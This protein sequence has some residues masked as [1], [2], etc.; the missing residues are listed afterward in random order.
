MIK[1]STFTFYNSLFN[2]SALNS[3][4]IITLCF[5][6]I[7]P[8]YSSTSSM[9]TLEWSNSNDRW[10]GYSCSIDQNRIIASSV[11][12]VKLYQKVGNDWVVKFQTPTFGSN[13]MVKDSFIYFSNTIN[14]SGEI[15]IYK[16]NP[17]TSWT[18]YQT[19]SPPIQDE[20][21]DD[22][23]IDGSLHYGES[24][25]L[26][27]KYLV[28]G[29]D[30]R[31]L[32]YIYEH[33]NDEWIL[34]Q[35][36]KS[37]SIEHFGYSVAI[38]D[39]TIFVGA[40]QKL[41]YTN[42]Q[43][44][45]ES[46]SIYIL[47][48]DNSGWNFTD[49]IK[50]PDKGMLG[51]FGSYITVNENHLFVSAFLGSNNNGRNGTVH[52][53]DKI[54][55]NWIY[56]Q[57]LSA[58][59]TNYKNIGF[60]HRTK[61]NGDQLA[62][63]APNLLTNKGNGAIYL[64]KK[65]N[66]IWIKN[67][68]FDFSQFENNGLSYDHCGRCIA[69]SDS[70]IVVG[71]PRLNSSPIGRIYVFNQPTV[72][73]C[74]DSID[75][76]LDG[77]IDC[78]DS[79]CINTNCNLIILSEICD[80]LIDN[81]NDGL[82]DCSDSDCQNLKLF[83]D[84]DMDGFGSMD[85]I[86][87]SSCGL[88]SGFVS[89]STDCNDLDP[90][91]YHCYEFIINTHFNT[92][93]TN[94][95]DGN[96]MDINGN[97]SLTAAFQ[98]INSSDSDELY[99][100]LFNLSYQDTI[101]IDS[102]YGI[103]SDNKVVINGKQIHSDNLI[104]F[105]G[106]NYFGFNLTNSSVENLILNTKVIINGENSKYHNCY[107]LNTVETNRYNNTDCNIVIDSCGFGYHPNKSTT[108]PN[109]N[110]IIGT[111]NLI[112]DGIQ[113]DYFV[114]LPP[115]TG[116]TLKNSTFIK[117]GIKLYTGSNYIY[118]NTFSNSS[119][120]VEVFNVENNLI[121]KNTFHSNGI[122]IDIIS[123][124]GEYFY[125]KSS[126]KIDSIENYIYGSSIPFDTIQVYLNRSNI[127]SCQGEILIGSTISNQ[128][129]LWSLQTP[130]HIMPQNRIAAIGIDQIN[131][132]SEFS[133]YNVLPTICAFSQGLPVNINPCSTTGAVL[134]LSQMTTS[135]TA[136]TSAYA[137][138]FA[139]R[140]AWLQLVI[141]STKNFLIRSNINNQIS[142]VIEAYKGTCDSLIFQGA[143]AFDS[144]VQEM[145]FENLTP[146]DTL[147]L[148]IWDKQNLKVNANEP[149]LHLTAHELSVNKDEWETCDDENALAL[150]NPT[151]ISEKDANSFIVPFPIGATSLDIA[152]EEDSL[153]A[154]GLV[155][156]DECLCNGTPLQ[157]WKA[158]NPVDMETKAKSAIGRGNVD[159]VN[160]NYIFEAQE[161]Q[162]NAY[163]TGN[164][165]DTDVSMDTEGNFV[166]CWIDQQRRHNY[167]RVF[168]SSGN[169]ITQEYRVGDSTEVQLA[170]RIALE[171][172]GEFVTVWQESDGNNYKIFGRQYHADGSA[173]AGQVD[174]SQNSAN[175]SSDAGIRNT[176]RYGTN[177][178]VDVDPSGNFIITWHVGSQVFA[179]RYTQSAALA[180]SIIQVG[181]IIEN[182]NTPNP[183]VS[184]NDNG[185][186][187][188]VWNGEDTDDH[189]IYAQLYNSN[190]IA[191]GPVILVNTI[192][193][194]NQIKPDVSLFN[195]GSFVVTWQSYEQEGAGLDYGIYAQRFDATGSPI[196]AEFLVN[197]HQPDTQKSPSISG[198]DDGRFFIAW[199]SY[200]Q[201]GTE[202]GVY[203]QLFAADGSLMGAEFRLNTFTDPDQ[204]EPATATNGTNLLI[205]S[206][207]DGGNEENDPT[208]GGSKGIFAQRYEIHSTA[209]GTNRI[210]LGTATPS[211]LLGDE[212]P[213]TNTIYQALDSVSN[214]RV[215]IIDTGIDPGHPYLAN[216]IWNNQQITGTG[217]HNGD[218]MGYDY[219]NNS[220]N[221]LDIDGHGTKVNGII[222]K[223]F[224]PDVQLEMMNIKFHE[225]DK[226]KVFDALCGLYYAVD[227]GAKVI[228]MSWGFEASERPTILE[229]ALQ[230]ASDNDVLIVTTA[231]NTS[232]NNDKVKKYPSN[233]DIE[234]MI[235]VTA[236]T[237]S[238]STGNIKLANYASYGKQKV[239][240]AAPG[241]VETTNIGDTLSLSAG[242][243]LA[244][245]F[246]TRTAATIRGLY[247]ILTAEEVKE[248]ILSSA[249]AETNLTNFVSTGGILDHNAALECA[250]SK[251]MDCMGIDLFITV[252]QNIDTTYRSDAW[253]NSDATINN[254][255]NVK[256][257]GAEY[258]GLQPDFKV[259]LGAEYLADIDDCAP[260][261]EP[262]D[263]VSA[264]DE[265]L[266]FSI[267]A[268]SPNTGKIKSKFYSDGINPVSIQI[269][270]DQ[271]AS[272]LEW[273]S[274]VLDKGWYEKI[275]DVAGVK[276]GDYEIEF[277]A[278]QYQA[279]KTLKLKRHKL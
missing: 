177:P 198:F 194:H 264:D 227:N 29:A 114:I 12:R 136:P 100:V 63:S 52:V 105:H 165:Y 161:F 51:L 259:E 75:N 104:E 96:C 220:N 112:Y 252:N 72:E 229:K 122:G 159:T 243:S 273:K 44:G 28:V 176:A 276:S 246:V 22:I 277:S 62:I 66:G 152:I 257:Y 24:F 244:A 15:E 206:W 117:S 31:N 65:V 158:G 216:T 236:Y 174:I 238:N 228:N 54:G 4:F 188:I 201:D 2:K 223:D 84:Q 61:V 234:S 207:V 214:V 47:Q 211:S 14:C 137:N 204:E 74:N 274:A 202:E 271:G 41:I 83:I 157:L 135:Q 109:S 149:L 103:S 3:L 182:N 9:T 5:V 160:Y 203:G 148:R 33:K 68:K 102:I 172:G 38:I 240:I 40:P 186:F 113:W 219:Y 226:G 10:V 32:I 168:N 127:G 55:V 20:Y 108:F 166:L 167:A 121:S 183:S 115:S 90:Q 154:Q 37:N 133:C 266:L 34:K 129:G 150:G 144:I 279:A 192:E 111:S 212:V 200:D 132:T 153:T 205:G 6:L 239:H 59:D 26:F 184:M 179:Q 232:K 25:A 125:S 97:C 249:Q 130:Q 215:A 195:D 124:N 255:S 110:L 146:G 67:L 58:T 260:G 209:T 258:V 98:E 80:D 85:S 88:I 237:F 21:C 43:P 142:P 199:D 156:E 92:N 222:A 173:K 233:F 263:F 116:H 253:V 78:I 265:Q 143:A 77:Q 170:G 251:A 141:P 217:C 147:Y 64:Y 221:P 128:D 60:G 242:T 7:S 107:F 8:S 180:G 250:S 155:K 138:T 189:G 87:Y 181:F 39:S 95:G 50:S 19:L 169:P 272:L 120:A 187:I 162:V 82:I 69:I 235:S 73:I 119:K 70:L 267:A 56:K 145:V 48:K 53:Y 106:D 230:Y 197:S 218:V 261:N 35:R 118:K 193:T 247:P 101:Y 76:D 213:Y 164:Q 134:D 99:Y 123:Y 91:Y 131:N 1:R 254:N 269:K 89:D 42:N 30:T 13:V 208:P 262:F 86:V 275:I 210:A 126:P 231:G 18:H 45:E 36:I 224:N 171:D 16:E 57:T 46:A 196:G 245:P 163:A 79:D 151:I 225:N 241:V 248:C 71:S 256:M 93:D 178:S 140:D 139:G 81:D 27:G 94:V 278:K 175:T 270:S 191:Q 49:T 11:N 17:D 185:E 268:H 190:G 23:G